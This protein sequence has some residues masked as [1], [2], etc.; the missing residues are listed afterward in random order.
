[1]RLGVLVVALLALAAVAPPA[2]A[3]VPAGTITVAIV[4]LPPGPARLNA[5]QTVSVGFNVQV[6][7]TNFQCT[8]PGAIDVALAITNAGAAP[9][10]VTAA[11]D[12]ANLSFPVQ[13]GVYGLPQPI[14]AGQPFNATLPATLRVTTSPSSSGNF[15][16]SVSA[17]HAA[18]QACTPTGDLPDASDTK[19]HQVTIQGQT[20]GNGTGPGPGPIGGNNTTEPPPSGNPPASKGL[21]GFEAAL[22]VTGLA[23]L[24]LRRRR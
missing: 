16:I 5:G 6:T 13:P 15:A 9:A 18:A 2:V 20:G 21:P 14:P 8:S 17:A 23:L 11:V 24:A 1:M 22:A 7:A 12:P 19:T 10:G 3:Q 4:D